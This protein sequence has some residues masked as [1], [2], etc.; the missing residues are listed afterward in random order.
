M[1]TSFKGIVGVPTT[2]YTEDGKVDLKTFGKHVNFLIENGSHLLAYP[3][4]GSESLNLSK[5]ELKDLARCLVESAGGR[6]PVFVNV[7]SSGTD[8]AHDLARHCEDVGATGIV[9]LPPYFWKP[10]KEE[11][12]DHFVTVVGDLNIK[13]IGYNNFGATQ[14]EIPHEVL[15][16]LIE[17]LP[18]FV[19]MKDASFDMKY[20]TEACRVTS[21]LNPEFALYT[22]IEYMLPSMVV[23]GSGSFSRAGKIAPR[24][25]LSLYEACAKGDVER[26]RPLQFKAVR[27]LNLLAHK[28]PASTKYAMELMGRPDGEPRKPLPRL[29]AEDKA[30]V[31]EML[32]SLCILEGEPHGW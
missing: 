14:I 24:L 6:L 13:L 8:L 19:G 21:E 31:K 22:G 28:S 5:E 25:I 7:S 30:R 16:H 15:A 1:A 32:T 2:P 3:M 29:N 18:N 23:G 11:L 10:A 20:F 4:H 9:L 12:I 27:L 26:A 17:R